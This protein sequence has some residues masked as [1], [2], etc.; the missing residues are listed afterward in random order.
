[1]YLAWLGPRAAFYLAGGFVEFLQLQLTTPFVEDEYKEVSE[2]GPD[3]SLV[4]ATFDTRLNI[5]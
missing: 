3:W 5:D 4:T 1:M 2:D